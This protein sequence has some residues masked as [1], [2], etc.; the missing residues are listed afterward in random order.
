MFGSDSS[1]YFCLV[2]LVNEYFDAAFT[3]LLSL[4]NIPQK[5]EDRV[6][7]LRLRICEK[8]VSL[9]QLTQ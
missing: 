4:E 8:H 2:V 9:M 3:S 1:G 7:D 6:L 5:A